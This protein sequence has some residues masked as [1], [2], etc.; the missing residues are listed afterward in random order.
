[1]RQL[2]DNLKLDGRRKSSA[3]RMMNREINI[4]QRADPAPERQ[5]CSSPGERYLAYYS[6]LSSLDKEKD[7]TPRVS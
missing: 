2:A 5:R 4:C 7:S 3:T 1:M 6:T